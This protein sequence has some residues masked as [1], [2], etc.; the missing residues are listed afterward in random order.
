MQHLT[1]MELLSLTD[2]LLVG[3]FPPLLF[4]G[5]DISGASQVYSIDLFWLLLLVKN[6]SLSALSCD[7]IM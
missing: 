7:K 5:F 4:S 6:S 1:M 2:P 3:K